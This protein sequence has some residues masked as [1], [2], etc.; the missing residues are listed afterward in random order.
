[1]REIN[2]LGVYGD[3]NAVNW[4][5]IESPFTQFGYD[6]LNNSTSEKLVIGEVDKVFE[7]YDI[8]IFKYMVHQDLIAE[9]LAAAYKTKTAIYVDMD[10]NVFDIPPSSSANKYWPEEAKLNFK[11]FAEN[12]AGIICSTEPL[13]EV[14]REYNDNV[15][16]IPNKIDPDMWKP[17]AKKGPI[18]IGWTYSNTH[19]EEAH[20]FPKIMEGVKKRHPEV[21]FQIV[22][23]K[24][25]GAKTLDPCYFKD[26]PK[27]L[28]KWNWDISLGLLE[29]NP[30]NDAKSNIKWLE[31]TMA[32]SVFVGSNELPY[33]TSIVN[34]KTGFLCKTVDEF[35][36]TICTLIEDEELRK[37]IV[38]NARKEV[39]KNWNI[40]T[41]KNLYTNLDTSVRVL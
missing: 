16:V 18:K 13:A 24:A 29:S 40:Q 32:K 11:F 17:R 33:N 10:D 19:R 31:S 36:D 41:S 22:S 9:V 21:E 39:L 4:Y 35:V 34:G 26:F 14:M 25:V 1:M 38:N 3:Q 27:K 5:R 8:V 15:V 6:I 2:I 30:F 20:M 28:T 37:D 23:G 12:I 7:K